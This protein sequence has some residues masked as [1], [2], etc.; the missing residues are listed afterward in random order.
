[1]KLEKE[2]K[3][4]KE[5]R[6]VMLEKERIV[7]QTIDDKKDWRRKKKVEVDYRKIEKIVPRKFLKCLEK[8]NQKECQ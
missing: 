8:Q 2:Q 1:M 4:K 7:R 5:K 3:V 6:V